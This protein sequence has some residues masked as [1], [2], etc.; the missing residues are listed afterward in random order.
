MP[1][2]QRTQQFF[3]EL[4]ELI[5]ARYPIIQVATFEEDRFL[6]KLEAL[7]KELGRPITAWSASRGVYGLGD[8]AGKGLGPHLANADL[9]VALEVFEK[10]AADKSR[11][12]TGELFLLLDPEP[13]LNEPHVNPIYRRRLKD[14]AI[15]VRLKGYRAS[16][17]IVS[18]S[19]TV[20]RDL[21]KEVTIIDFP[22]PS[23]DEV[24]G[25]IKR[26][27]G[28]IRGNS[29]LEVEDGATL[30]AALINASLGL[31]YAEIQS[32]LTKAIVEDR[33]LDFRDV[34]QIFRQ[35]QQIIRKSGILDYIDA[36][37]LSLDQVGGLANLKQWFKT[38]EAAFSREGRDYGIRA[39]RGV[40]LTGVP[41]C[42]KSWSAR[43]VAATWR[44]PLLRLDMGKVYSALV[45]SS[46][47]HLRTAVQ[48]A[49]SVAPCVLWIDEIEKG[50]SAS[51]GYVGDNGVSLRVLGGFLTWLQEKTAPV[52]VFA[53]V[54]QIEQLPAEMLRKG[55]FD[56]IF[57]VDLPTDEE[58]REIIKIHLGE[59]GRPVEQFDLDELVRLSGSGQL[60]PDVALT[61][62]EIAAWVNEALIQSFHRRATSKRDIGMEDFR[63][64]SQHIVPLARMRAADIQS[65]RHWGGEHA[66]HASRIEP[67]IVFTASAA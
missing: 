62:A 45:G 61:G 30:E 16:C 57:F 56:E 46:E 64:I 27:L 47:E 1:S 59:I 7:A 43:C 63:A 9:A 19:A 11:G 23:R 54:N 31:T 18:S 32:V 29:A 58:R 34:E 49:E 12:K 17:I 2:R 53:T 38:R 35:K 24:S 13:Y 52:F 6:S 37:G 25:L 40:L 15:N 67:D 10:L 3:G 60:G 14:F 20:H 4:R 44:L 48:T 21:E 50:L 39:P 51:R 55:R 26:I 5:D 8:E 28:T 66:V 22:L 65:M 42:G 33:R 36:R 41:G